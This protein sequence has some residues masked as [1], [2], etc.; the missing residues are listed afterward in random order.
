MDAGQDEDTHIPVLADLLEATARASKLERPDFSSSYLDHLVSLPLDDLLREPSLISNE[1]STIESEL[2]NLCFREYSTFTS[3]H[4]CSA[5]VQSAFDDFDVSLTRLLDSVPALE[6]ECRTFTSATSPIQQARAKATLVQEHQ[7]K[8]LE[9]LE[10]PRL[11]DACVRN[12]YYQEAM[13]LASHTELLGTRYGVALV[14]DVAEEVGDVVQVMLAQLLALL[15]EPVKL[16]T[17][18]KAVSFLRRLGTMTESELGLVF[19]ASRL[20]NF[21]S[22][23]EHIERDRIEPVRYVRKYVDLFREHV[24]D[25]ISQFSAIFEASAQLVSFASQC[26]G[27]LVHLVSSYVPRVASDSASL[28]SILVQLAYCAQSF[29]RVGLDFSALVGEPFTDSVLAIY[30]QAVSTTTLDLSQTLRDTAK[31]AADPATLFAQGSSVQ[32]FPPL[33]LF[34]NGHL[35]ALNSLRLL[36]PMEI[37][38]NVV[39][40]QSD[41]LTAATQAVLQFVQQSGAADTPASPRARLIRRNTETQLTPE[42]RLARKRESKR[43]LV[44]L[45]DAWIDVVVPILVNGLQGGV[46]EEKADPVDAMLA[47]LRA[48]ADAN[49]ERRNDID[50]AIEELATAVNGHSEAAARPDLANGL[51][52]DADTSRPIDS[53]HVAVTT[54]VSDQYSAQATMNSDSAMPTADSTTL[55][56]GDETSSTAIDLPAAEPHDAPASSP[57]L[58]TVETTTVGDADATPTVAVPDQPVSNHGE[59]EIKATFAGGSEQGITVEPAF[60]MPETLVS[61]TSVLEPVLPLAVNTSERLEAGLDPSVPGGPVEHVAPAAVETVF[62]APANLE[63]ETDITA[64][65]KVGPETSPPSGPVEHV[66]PEAVETIF[67]PSANPEAANPEADPE[68]AEDTPTATGNNSEQDEPSAEPNA[69]T[70]PKKKKKKK[71]KK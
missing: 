36:A 40:V 47:E 33:A 1:S 12:G 20:Y 18:V 24:Y 26:V 44:A 32:Q 63:P 34:M 66:A 43:V 22:Q 71:S 59:D 55:A 56:Y 70:K 3:V 11:M 45:A 27:D 4:R 9:L 42:G 30:A 25:I 14:Q 16:P 6:A 53:D 61:Q 28:S 57:G 17:L 51:D 67:L 46:Y 2:V 21:R 50:E 15:R 19:L 68:V 37:Y 69:A 39:R 5:A 62:L 65:L 13:E 49:R 23:L 38:P 7:D 48:W 54:A 64:K 8:L 31:S 58:D 35:S 10:I 41:S 52:T 29:A 60:A